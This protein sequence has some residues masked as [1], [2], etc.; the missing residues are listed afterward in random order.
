MSR[1]IVWLYG[2]VIVLFA[3]LVGFTSRWTVF[4]AESLRDNPNNRRQII[5]EARIKRGTIRAANGTVLAR[6]VRQRGKTYKRFYPRP[7]LFPHE[8]GY[9]FLTR[10]RTGLEAFY[11]DELAGR[12][13]ELLSL[14]ER[15]EGRRQEGDDLRTTLDPQAQEV[16]LSALA[17]RRGS[18]VALEP[19]T[20]AVRVMA[21]VPGFDPNDADDSERFAQLTRSED[22]PLVN[23]AIAGRYPPGSTFKVVTAAAALDTGRYTPDSVVDGSNGKLIGGV[24]LNNFGDQDYGAVDLTT[25]LTQSVNTVWAEV[26]VELGKRTMAEYMRRFGFYKDPPIDL[27]RNERVPSGEFSEGRLL[28]PESDEI[29]VGRMAIGQDKLSVTPLQMALVA[30]TVANGGVMVRPHIGDRFVDPDGRTTERVTGKSG[31]RA[32]S[33]EAADALTQMMGNVVREG[34]GTA[35][36]LEGV[37]VAGKTGTAEIIVGQ[38]NQPWFIGFAPLGSPRVAVAVTVERSDGTGGEVAAPIARQVLQALLG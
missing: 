38:V 12:E 13:G 29:D 17:G 14:V 3:L 27:P 21:S 37:E 11:N 9:A 10:G 20:G 35:A 5:E 30:A 22:D 4:E 26:G 24:P 16:A 15:L 36:A 31:G 2:L 25:A 7:D 19:S 28:D 33:K 32:M 1:P 34:S 23:R 8:V 18:V 6:S